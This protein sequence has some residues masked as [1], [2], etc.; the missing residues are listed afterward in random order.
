MSPQEK[1]IREILQNYAKTESLIDNTI[2]DPE[3]YQHIKKYTLDYCTKEMLFL[4]NE[5]H[6]YGYI[7]GQEKTQRRLIK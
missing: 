7:D 6:R 1:E 5:A 3:D 2:G 4:L